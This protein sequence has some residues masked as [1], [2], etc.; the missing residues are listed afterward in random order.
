MMARIGGIFNFVNIMWFLAIVG[1]TVSVGPL[2]WIVAS[3]I[4][5]FLMI[6]LSWLARGVRQFFWNY[7]WPAT[8]KL[9]TWGFLELFA[10]MV[11]FTILTQSHKMNSNDT[12]ACFM[13][14]LTAHA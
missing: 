14:A 5:E 9:H 13:V 4:V 6:R 10:Y 1:I 12:I 11:T 7:V 2:L 3:P 8:V